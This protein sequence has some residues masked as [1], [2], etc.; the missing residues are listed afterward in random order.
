[1]GNQLIVDKNSATLGLPNEI[2]VLIAENRQCWQPE[3]QAGWN[4]S[5]KCHTLGHR[6]CLLM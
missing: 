3:I 1:M 5:Q 2:S 6:K 4:S